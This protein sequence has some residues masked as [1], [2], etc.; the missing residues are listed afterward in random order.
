MAPHI[1]TNRYPRCGRPQPPPQITRREDPASVP[2]SFA[3]ALAHAFP[4][5]R[6]PRFRVVTRGDH[7][8]LWRCPSPASARPPRRE[9]CEPSGQYV[10]APLRHNGDSGGPRHSPGWQRQRVGTAEVVMPLGWGTILG[11]GT[12]RSKVST[13]S[14]EVIA[15]SPTTAEEASCLTS[16]SRWSRKGRARLGLDGALTSIVRPERMRTTA[17]E[18]K[19]LSAAAN[20]W[21][22]P[23]LRPSDL[24]P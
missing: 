14:H 20:S 24:P 8:K 1:W 10:Y 12:R 16:E 13:G 11:E 9:I 23:G 5:L 2:P 21:R 4:P 3:H 22:P 15:C 19:Q 17:R 7:Y 18:C 6:S